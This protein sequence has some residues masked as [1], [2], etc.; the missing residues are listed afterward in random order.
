MVH[1]LLGRV[2]FRRFL[3]LLGER[4]G[5]TLPPSRCRRQPLRKLRQQ[6]ETAEHQ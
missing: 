5:P 3:R 6:Q 1:S 2:S 4:R